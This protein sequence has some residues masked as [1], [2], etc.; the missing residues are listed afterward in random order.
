M[1]RCAPEKIERLRRERKLRPV[2]IAGTGRFLP[3]RIL[4]NHDLEEMVETS[5]EW[6]VTRTGIRERRIAGEG[7][8]TSHLGTEAAR[9]ALEAAKVDPAEVEMIIVATITPD[10]VFPATA[11]LVQDRIGAPGAACFDLEAACSGFVYGLDVGAQFIATES[12][13][14]IL[15]IAAEKIS[16]IVDWNDRGT[17]V[18]FGDGA[19]AAVLRPAEKGSPSL[20]ILATCLGSDGGQ[21]DILKLPGGG[22]LH[23]ASEETV[24]KGMHYLQMAGR[25]VF[26]Q[27]IQAMAQAAENVLEKT[28]L[29]VDD[30]DWVIPHQANIRIIQ[31]ISDKLGIPLDRF[32]NNVDRYGNMSAATVPVALDEAVREGR[33]RTG[34]LV[35]FLVFGG[36]LTWGATLVHW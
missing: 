4:T 17:C 36:G 35:L 1:P 13:D 32:Y 15:V 20:G 25:G 28:G 6:I 3:E 10:M 18:L 7:V 14:T 5:D 9:R 2:V 24:R 11:C 19:G 21:A 8:A 12:M 31:A 33:I 22:S 29:D 34:D 16:A 30:I 27:A 26:R 23:P